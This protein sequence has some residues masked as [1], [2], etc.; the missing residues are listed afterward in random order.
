MEDLQTG[1]NYP[2][3]KILKTVEFKNDYE[4]TSV[5]KSVNEE[6]ATIYTFTTFRFYTTLDT[7]DF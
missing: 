4:N 5:V 6:G 7:N 2:Q 3:E 1:P